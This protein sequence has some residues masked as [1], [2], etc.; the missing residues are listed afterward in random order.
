M[1]TVGQPS[2]KWNF[3]NGMVI[4]FHATTKAAKPTSSPRRHDSEASG[5]VRWGR[6]FPIAGPKASKSNNERCF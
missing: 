2:D 6:K 1:V 5:N 3:A 4:S